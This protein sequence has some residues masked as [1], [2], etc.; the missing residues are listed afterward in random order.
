MGFWN[1][2]KEKVKS[3]YT[4][5]DKKYFGGSL[6]GGAP[7]GDT[8]VIGKEAPASQ[9][10]SGSSGSTS[11][12]TTGGGGTIREQ[13]MPIFSEEEAKSI[14][15]TETKPYWVAQSKTPMQAVEEGRF[16]GSTPIAKTNTLFGHTMA[17]AKESTENI[18][19]MQN[20]FQQNTLKGKIDWNQAQQ[21][22]KEAW[23]TKWA[24]LHDIKK[25]ELFQNSLVVGV[26]K[27]VTGIGE[28]GASIVKNFGVQTY[29]VGEKPSFWG[30][31]VTFSKSLNDYPIGSAEI[32]GLTAV[33]A[34][35][36]NLGIKGGVEAV[37][38]YGWGK[39]AIVIAKSFN[40][41][42]ITPTTYKPSLK[43]SV[44]KPFVFN[45]AEG[46]TYFG[47]FTESAG[48]KFAGF[49]KPDM[50]NPKA[51]RG[52]QLTE[53]PYLTITPTGDILTGRVTSITPYFSEGKV[54]IG[55]AVKATDNIK[56]SGKEYT[57]GIST[58][59]YTNIA[60]IWTP[61]KASGGV[62]QITKP[63]TKII[64]GEFTGG[65]QKQLDNNFIKIFKSGQSSSIP[66]WWNSERVSVYE[67]SG[68][69][70]VNKIKTEGIEFD[71]TKIPSSTG[72]MEGYGQG[73]VPSGKKASIVGS[74]QLP[75]I[76]IV[77][78]TINS[79]IN[80]PS[81]RLFPVVK[82]NQQRGGYARDIFTDVKLS[83]K[84]ATLQPRTRMVNVPVLQSRQFG[85]QMFDTT[86]RFENPALNVPVPALRTLQKSKQQYAQ[87]GGFSYPRPSR[88]II[89]SPIRNVPPPF[90]AFPSAFSWGQSA[91][92]VK[93][94]KRR[95][96]YN[97]SFT[98]IVFKKFGKRA[99]NISQKIGI[100][101]ANIPRGFKFN[102]GLTGF[103]FGGKKFRL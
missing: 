39:G 77:R 57:G 94:G 46:K 75:P 76:N 19:T 64:T 22:G 17:T 20:A 24:G 16:I 45:F 38:T 61:S 44:A 7:K 65:V 60:D 56:I 15:A 52:I 4:Q 28:F 86:Q 55:R 99:S 88:P 93:G 66:N 98:A 58:N 54:G 69:Y 74:V 23:N 91:R 71:L 82:T 26:A 6:P 50:I 97:P 30:R 59:F 42:D 27:G 34:P 43:G 18:G 35:T 1:T 101:Y 62:V 36:L 80:K 9:S 3:G 63:T 53:R 8:I 32:A 96:G 12:G 78:P 89:E 47:G 81:T 31:G 70:K 5:A 49:E 11:A 83:L 29:Q 102:T 87:L 72:E 13:G 68:K 103:N 95:V 41:I 21:A 33:Y 79:P 14:S 51:S 48:S 73:F 84:E 37:K 40:P 67:P 10:S 90:I 85:G 100:A 92:I 2:I 25:Q